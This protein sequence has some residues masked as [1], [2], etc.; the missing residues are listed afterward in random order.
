MNPVFAQ[1]LRNCG[2]PMPIT[3]HEWEP[4]GRKWRWDYSWPDH[5]VA[6]EVDG[7]GWQGGR[8]HRKLGRDEDNEKQNEAMRF[9]WRVIRVDPQQLT[10]MDTMDLLADL[11]EA[12]P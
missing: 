3:E 7:G 5:K 10:T 8:H 11:L 1:L 9:G 12:S 4:T 2:L 6:L